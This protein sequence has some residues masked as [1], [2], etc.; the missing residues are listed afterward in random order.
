MDG[1]L[2]HVVVDCDDPDALA[3][4]WS[5][6]LGVGVDHRFEQY[7]FLEPTAAGGPALAFQRVPEPKV[8]KNRLHLDIVVPELAPA[9]EELLALGATHLRSV[10]EEGIRLEVLA[11]PEGNELCLV[12]AGT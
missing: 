5:A 11:D 10:D 12:L 7:V 4:F 8:G 1:R 6:A 3:A 2:S 9:V